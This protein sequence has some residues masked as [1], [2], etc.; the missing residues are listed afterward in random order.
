MFSWVCYYAFLQKNVWFLDIRSFWVFFFLSTLSHLWVCPIGAVSFAV[1]HITDNDKSQLL[2]VWMSLP[3]AP[4]WNKVVSFQSVWNWLFSK[5]R[6]VIFNFVFFALFCRPVT[7]S[8]FWE[9]LY[10]IQWSNE[11]EVDVFR[12]GFIG[13]VLNLVFFCI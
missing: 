3:N 8:H 1:V 7:E 13:F 10:I 6:I 9:I 2:H 4:R 12:S 11:V 5:K